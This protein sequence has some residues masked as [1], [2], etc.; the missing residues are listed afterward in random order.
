MIFTWKVLFLRITP[1][2]QED[3][4]VEVTSTSD[5]EGVAVELP[6]AEQYK[7]EEIQA[8]QGYWSMGDGTISID[9]F[10]L[11]QTGDGPVYTYKYEAL[12]VKQPE[13]KIIKI[14]T[15]GSE[16]KPLKAEFRITEMENS[17]GKGKS[18]TVTTQDSDGIGIADF[19]PFHIF[20]CK[21]RL[22]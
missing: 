12:N 7:I 2:G 11:E 22:W 8:P 16:Q 9:R 19:T 13:L 14:G 6:Y 1:I 18:I 15:N 4:A 10:Q 5:P 21:Y 3:K 20:T 17:S